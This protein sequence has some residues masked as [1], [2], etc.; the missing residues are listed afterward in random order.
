MII[1]VLFIHQIL[2]QV[3]PKPKEVVCKQALRYSD[4]N[5]GDQYL[6]GQH[7]L[8]V[9]ASSLALSNKTFQCCYRLFSVCKSGYIEREQGY[10]TVHHLV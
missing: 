1:C 7:S 5:R 2:E 4:R 8:A 10:R 9:A 3:S 6:P